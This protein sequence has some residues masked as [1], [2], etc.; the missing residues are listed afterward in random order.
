M[1]TRDVQLY[2]FS[3]Q[4]NYHVALQLALCEGIAYETS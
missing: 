2:L 1:I 4:S 3:A